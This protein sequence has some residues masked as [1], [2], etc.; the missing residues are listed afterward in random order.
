MCIDVCRKKLKDQKVE[1]MSEREKCG[2]KRERL[3]EIGGEREREGYKEIVRGR[4]RGEIQVAS[5]LVY[6]FISPYGCKT[7]GVLSHQRCLV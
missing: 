2:R 4:E 5:S 3:K 7:A 1:C 6:Y